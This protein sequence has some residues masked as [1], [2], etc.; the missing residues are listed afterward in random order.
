MV[1]DIS[2]ELFF[3][4]IDA[5]AIDLFVDQEFTF[6]ASALKD[7]VLEKIGMIAKKQLQQQQQPNFLY[8]FCRGETQNNSELP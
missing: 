3:G 1:R 2:E 7:N 4:V 8:S 5:P 6:S